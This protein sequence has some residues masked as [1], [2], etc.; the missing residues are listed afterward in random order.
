M[1]VDNEAAAIRWRMGFGAASSDEKV[2]KRVPVRNGAGVR[3]IG[4]FGAERGCSDR[5]SRGGLVRNGGPKKG[6]FEGGLG[7]NG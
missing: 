3:K 4:W 5:T 1:F 6:R 2:M 7:G